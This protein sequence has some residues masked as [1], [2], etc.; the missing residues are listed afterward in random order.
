ME[1]RVLPFIANIASVAFTISPCAKRTRTPNNICGWKHFNR[2]IPTLTIRTCELVADD[3]LYKKRSNMRKW[4][5]ELK[6][7]YICLPFLPIW[8]NLTSYFVCKLCACFWWLAHSSLVS[9]AATCREK[10]YCN[11]PQFEG[12]LRGLEWSPSS[13]SRDKNEHGMLWKF[14]KIS[15]TVFTGTNVYWCQ[16]YIGSTGWCAKHKQDSKIFNSVQPP[17]CAKPAVTYSK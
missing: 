17:H 10:T 5:L 4:S 6:S 12:G 2:Q 9:S 8:I 14:E 3:K 15:S 16:A 13:S 1:K 7:S 11:P